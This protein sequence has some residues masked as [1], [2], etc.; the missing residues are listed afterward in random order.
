[1]ACKRCGH[2]WVLPVQSFGETLMQCAACG[3]VER[4]EDDASST[5]QG[6]SEGRDEGADDG[7]AKPGR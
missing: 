6:L 7:E 4:V 2:V 3:Y 1:M 5:H